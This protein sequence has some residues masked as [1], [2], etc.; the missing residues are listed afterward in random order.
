M[1]VGGSD[2]TNGGKEGT[3]FCKSLLLL[4]REF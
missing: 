1:Y 3:W 2:F 4:N